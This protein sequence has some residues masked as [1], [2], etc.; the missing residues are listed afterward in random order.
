MH[1]KTPKI[2]RVFWTAGIEDSFSTLD[3]LALYG[4]TTDAQQGVVDAD[5]RS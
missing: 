1:L 3:Y 4:P 2:R 5:E